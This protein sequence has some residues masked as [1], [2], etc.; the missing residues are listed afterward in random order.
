MYSATIVAAILG[1]AGIVTAIPLADGGAPKYDQNNNAIDAY[2]N[3][4][5]GQ[6]N[7]P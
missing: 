1:V 6:P 4:W 5:Q 7:L 3:N 2:D